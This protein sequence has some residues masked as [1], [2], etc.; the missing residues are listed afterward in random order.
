MRGIINLTDNV[1]N[2]FTLQSRV[3]PN[4]SQ[5]SELRTPAPHLESGLCHLLK[6]TMDFREGIHP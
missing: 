5:R 3:L 4:A 6:E 1:S 2:G